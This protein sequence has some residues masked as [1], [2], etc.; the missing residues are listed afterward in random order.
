MSTWLLVSCAPLSAFWAPAS[1]GPWSPSGGADEELNEQFWH[2]VALQDVQVLE[3]GLWTA[4][5]SIDAGT[6]A[7]PAAAEAKALEECM[8]FVSLVLPEGEDWLMRGW[9]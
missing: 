4:L 6:G 5:Q 1:T 7:A 2:A 3:R 8:D 9:L